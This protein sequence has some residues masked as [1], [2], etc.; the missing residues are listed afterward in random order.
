L[1]IAAPKAEA[2]DRIATANGSLCIRDAAKTL[3]VQE[4]ALYQHL[5]AHDWIYRRPMGSGWLAYSDILKRGLMEHKTETGQKPDGSEWIRT[6]P[7]ITA[8]GMAKLAGDF[9]IPEPA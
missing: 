2:L 6:Q 4:K 9:S 1:A 8:K 7:R 3:Q 5:S